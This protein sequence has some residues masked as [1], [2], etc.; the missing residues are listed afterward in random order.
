MRRG[1][2]LIELIVIFSVIATLVMLALAAGRGDGRKKDEGPPPVGPF[3]TVL[4]TRVYEGHWFVMGTGFATH[5][6]DCPC[7]TKKAEA[8]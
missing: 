7:E 6:P 5:H 4:R 3:D 2:T 8:E 1:S